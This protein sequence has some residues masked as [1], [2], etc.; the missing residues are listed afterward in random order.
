MKLYKLYH[1]IGQKS[2]HTY[3]K[4][5]MLLFEQQYYIIRQNKEGEKQMAIII[6]G[7]RTSSKGKSKLK[8]RG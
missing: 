2:K 7:K 6:N 8:D 3:L 1:Q 4:Q 5:K